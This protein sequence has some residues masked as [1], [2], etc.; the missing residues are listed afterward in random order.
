[1][2]QANFQQTTDTKFH[3]Q[4]TFLLSGRGTGTIPSASNDENYDRQE[5]VFKLTLSILANVVGGALVLTAMFNLPI[6]LAVIWDI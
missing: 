2:L 6:I 5:S 1:M 4:A 3:S